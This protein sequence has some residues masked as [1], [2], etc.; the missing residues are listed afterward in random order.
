MNTYAW[1]NKPWRLGRIKQAFLEKLVV[2]V[3]PKDWVA[4]IA[5][6]ADMQW[7][8]FDEVAGETGHILNLAY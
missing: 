4:V 5:P 2:V 7:D 6:Q 1:I 3:V 8:T